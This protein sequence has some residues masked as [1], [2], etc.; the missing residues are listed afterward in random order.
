MFALRAFAVPKSVVY[1][2]YKS[3]CVEHGHVP[4]EKAAFFR[5]LGR[6]TSIETH[7]KRPRVVTDGSASEYY[8]DRTGRA[9]EKPIPIFDTGVEFV[10]HC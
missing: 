3:H 6:V 9:L 7:A 2:A 5:Q 8:L 10:D 4:A 1:A